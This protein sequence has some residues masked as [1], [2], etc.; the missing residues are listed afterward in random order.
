M[1]L[2]ASASML[3]PVSVSAAE[4]TSG[5]SVENHTQGREN[6]RIVSG[7]TI[8]DVTAPEEGILLDEYAVVS[9]AE[10]ETWEIPVIWI[11]ED[12]NLG[13]G[14]AGKGSYLPVLAYV[15]PDDYTISSNDEG[16]WGYRITLSEDLL[17]LFGEEKI[18]SVYENST[19][20]TYIL[21]AKLKDLFA[22]KDTVRNPTDTAGG[23]MVPADQTDPLKDHT[24]EEATEA[25][26]EGEQEEATEAQTEGEQEE[27]TEAQTEGEQEE[28][29]EAETEN[30]TEDENDQN[31]Y[32][33]IVNVH[34]DEKA[35]EALTDSDLEY[36]ADLVVNTLQPQAVNLLIEKFP[37]LK[38]A[39][40]N[41]E[42]GKNLA[43]VVSYN[44]GNSA[45]CYA[46]HGWIDDNTYPN[47]KFVYNLTVNASPLTDHKEDGKSVITRDVSSEA[48]T[49]LANT[50][51]HEL[52]HC[53]SYDYN[54]PG[55]T[56]QL[57]DGSTLRE[58]SP[59]VDFPIWFKEGAASTVE[60]NWQLRRDVLK[61]LCT[62]PG[63]EEPGNRDT[64]VKR[65]VDGIYRRGEDGNYIC[66]YNFDLEYCNGTDR[67]GNACSDTPSR[68]VSGYLAC[69]YL[70]E[71]AAA[72]DPA[73]GTSISE[74]G[75]NLVFNSDKLR[76]GMNSIIER[77]H[78]GETLDHVI[79]SISGGIPGG[80]YKD[81]ADFEA[82]FIKGNKDADGKYSLSGDAASVDFVSDFMNYMN[83]IDQSRE[84]G[85]RNH[86]ANGSVLFDFETDFR[87]P[88]N[89]EGAYSAS[90]L[91]PL[92][93]KGENFQQYARS[94]VGD[95]QA[96][97]T[98]GKSGSG[99]PA[100]AVTGSVSN[101]LSLTASSEEVSD[102]QEAAEEILEKAGEKTDA[103]GITADSEPVDV[104]NSGSVLSDGGISGD[105]VDYS[106]ADAP[107]TG[108][109]AAPETGSAASPEAAAEPASET[110]PMAAPDAASEPAPEAAATA[111]PETENAA[112]TETA[113]ESAPAA[114][115]LTVYST[116]DAAAEL[117]AA[118]ASFPGE[119]G[120]A[121]DG[122]AAQE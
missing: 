44:E 83:I 57:Y 75:G 91:Q 63:S 18:I 9:T 78:N 48:L 122:E 93:D 110:A 24:E 42:I 21:P 66:D 67:Y 84:Y 39:A 87:S 80:A 74:R 31:R 107:Q 2:A 76:L 45:S 15:V 90:V 70:Y 96:Y 23:E 8:G 104:E 113:A 38:K 92:D 47:S 34:C 22:Q 26:T 120:A 27:T 10:G 77:M 60:N 3:I 1:A 81:T 102:I 56:G 108:T 85:E 105:I 40:E 19:G 54:R 68:Y 101:Y 109:A 30:Q 106:P 13:T 64:I 94:T 112:V 35:K 99:T 119:T 89:F 43:V 72:K 6:A 41:N 59:D 25:Q 36:L 115:I 55:L 73:I 46:S 33:H 29:T 16:G 4:T 97:S 95:Q 20:I 69:M 103:A 121:S 49:E 50:V 12:L 111:V 79:N 5:V 51:V 82:R 32:P 100:R 114:E 116:D 71:L 58:Y 98:G 17:K 86:Y 14:P 65:Y 117:S 37:A 7:I 53:I 11:D 52:Y 28:T 62:S 88:L 61:L 118:E